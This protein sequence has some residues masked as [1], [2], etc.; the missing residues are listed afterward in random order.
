MQL[1]F[2]LPLA[3]VSRR[4]LVARGEEVP[5]VVGEAEVEARGDFVIVSGWHRSTHKKVRTYFAHGF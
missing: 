3:Q 4:R 2:L 1:H 5:A